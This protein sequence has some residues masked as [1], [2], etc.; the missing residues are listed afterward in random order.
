M[1]TET[2]TVTQRLFLNY[3]GSFPSINFNRIIR[4]NH[5]VKKKGSRESSIGYVRVCVEL[6]IYL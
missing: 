3:L 2:I 1:V 5:F 6:P 4:L